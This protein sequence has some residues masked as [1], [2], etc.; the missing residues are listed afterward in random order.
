MKK[1]I[2]AEPEYTYNTQQGLLT[3]LGDLFLTLKMHQIKNANPEVIARYPMPTGEQIDSLN[4]RVKEA[5][6]HFEEP[7]KIKR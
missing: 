4:N 6:K 1:E 5:F 3:D 7:L 2:C